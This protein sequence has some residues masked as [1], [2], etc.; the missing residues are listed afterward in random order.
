MTTDFIISKAEIARRK[1]AFVT[2][3]CS[4]TIGLVLTSTKFMS[5]NPWPA[6]IVISLVTLL[7]ALSS[8]LL[9]KFLNSVSKTK[10]YVHNEYLQRDDGNKLEEFLLN[11]IKK[12]L[13]KRTSRNTLRRITLVFTNQPPIVLNGLEHFEQFQETLMSKIGKNV[14][15][16]ES[17]EPL[18]FDHPLFYVFLGLLLSY[19]SVTFLKLVIAYRVLENPIAFAL[20]SWFSVAVGIWFILQKPLAK[21][22]GSQRQTT[23]YI[24]GLSLICAGIALYFLGR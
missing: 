9:F 17:Y 4:L 5:A 18:D 11:D 10:I 15:L 22:Y 20:L 8:I 6:I 1:K 3:A 2:L 13:I 7:L 14:I 16:T 24:W 19:T 12:I 23:D 21:E